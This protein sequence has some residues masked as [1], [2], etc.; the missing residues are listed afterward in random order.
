M[1]SFPPSPVPICLSI[2]SICPL[3]LLLSCYCRFAATADVAAAAAASVSPNFR[4]SQAD[5]EIC[6]RRKFQVIRRRCSRRNGPTVA[7]RRSSFSN[8][9]VFHRIS[10]LFKRQTDNQPRFASFYNATEELTHNADCFKLHSSRKRN[11]RGKA[12]SLECL[13]VT[14]L[15]LPDLIIPVERN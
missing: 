13:S 7:H 4:T 12:K 2:S 10:S 9:Y 11:E 5:R 8:A 6:P 3:H 14:P 15:A 1:L